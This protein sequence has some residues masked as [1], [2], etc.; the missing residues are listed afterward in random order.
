MA[1]PDTLRMY[2]RRS[3]K[4]GRRRLSKYSLVRTGD[5][6]VPMG[7]NANIQARGASQSRRFLKRKRVARTRR[8]PK[9]MAR[10]QIGDRWNK[11]HMKCGIN[12]NLRSITWNTRTLYRYDLTQL[13]L[14]ETLAPSTSLRDYQRINLHKVKV[15]TVIR[16]I[17]STS[18]ASTG[19]PWVVRMALV[20]R[21][22]KQ[23]Q[24][25]DESIFF[26]NH[27]N[28]LGAH[29]N[30]ELSGMEMCN[31]RINPDKYNVLWTKRFEMSPN[32]LKN[33]Q[34][35]KSYKKIRKTFKVHR[36]LDYETDQAT[37]CREKLVFLLW[38]DSDFSAPNTTAAVAG[39]GDFVGTIF[40]NDTQ[41]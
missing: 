2:Y 26:D 38:I 40:F 15:D 18:L 28:D 17:G 19:V 6:N 22:D 30:N 7:W 20:C 37:S 35:P 8:M 12:H 39:A 13:A 11:T 31:Y 16:A 1:Y 5:I 33:E 25:P 41:Y 21:R 4:Y 3:K 10:A 24:T 34:S 23:D 14:N 29:F 32:S 36:Q 9:K 27:T